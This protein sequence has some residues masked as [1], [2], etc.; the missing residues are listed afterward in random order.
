MQRKLVYTARAIQFSIYKIRAFSI[1]GFFIFQSFAKIGGTHCKWMPESIQSFFSNW[2]AK[3][4]LRGRRTRWFLPDWTASK[5]LFPLIFCRKR[6]LQ[7]RFGWTFDVPKSWKFRQTQ[8]PLWHC[9]LRHH[10]LRIGKICSACIQL[11]NDYFSFRDIR[12]YILEYPF[13]G[14]GLFLTCFHDCF[15]T[16][17]E[18]IR[19]RIGI[20]PCQNKKNHH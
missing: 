1:R 15:F 16:L 17:S 7:G 10:K 5:K 6:F 9:F 11:K 19:L 8:I 13:T 2:S 3:T 4:Y 14:I 20:L 18:Y 12:V